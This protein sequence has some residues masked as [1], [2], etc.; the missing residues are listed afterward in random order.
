ML[1]F[2]ASRDEYVKR[3]FGLSRSAIADQYCKCSVCVQAKMKSTQIRSLVDK[4]RFEIGKMWY[5]DLSGPFVESLIRKNVYMAVFVDSAAR[6]IISYYMRSKEGIEV[7]KVLQLFVAEYLISPRFDKTKAF[8]FLQSDNGEFADKKIKLL[9]WKSG[10]VQRYSAPYHSVSNGPVERAILKIKEMGKAFLIEKSMP[11]EYWEFSARMAVYVLNRTP[12]KYRNKW[13]EDA[14]SKFFGVVAD[15]T[16]F[17]IPFSVAYVLKPPN[18][19]RKDWGP[20]ACEGVLVGISDSTYTVFVPEFN[21]LF[22]SSNVTID[23][24]ATRSDSSGLHGT[25]QH[26]PFK[27]AYELTDFMYLVGTEH[28]DDENGLKYRVVKVRLQRLRHGS[29]VVVDRMLVGGSEW[30]TIFALD[31]AVSTGPFPAHL[32]QSGL[33]VRPATGEHQPERIVTVVSD[34]PTGCTNAVRTDDS[35]APYQPPNSQ[36]EHERLSQRVN[37]RLKGP[38][39]QPMYLPKDTRKSTRLSSKPPINFHLSKLTLVES[40]QVD[41]EVLSY[42]IPKRYAQAIA[43]ED[44]E[45]WLAA[46]TSE[47]KGLQEAECWIIEPMPLGAIALPCKWVYDVKTDDMGRLIRYK[48]RLVV[49]GNRQR[50]GVDFSETFSPTVSWDSVRLFLALTVKFGLVPLQLDINMAYLYA[51]IDEG[52]VIYMRPPPGMDVPDGY[53][54]RLLKRLY[55]FK[56]SGRNW[57]HLIHQKLEEAGFMRIDEDACVYMRVRDGK[58]T[59]LLIYVDDILCSASSKDLLAELLAYLRSL[60]KLKVMGVPTNIHMAPSQL[61]G[62]QLVWGDDFK[63]VQINASKIVNELLVES[64]DNYGKDAVAH[65]TPMEPNLRL[66]ESDQLKEPVDEDDI[67]MQSKYR[68]IVG[69]LIFLVTTCRVELSFAL[70]VLSRSMK[71][72]GRAHYKAA[73]HVLAY[74]SNKADLG[75]AYYHDGNRFPY[76]YADADF[77]SDE[78]RRA[79]MGYMFILAG[80]PISWKCK[81]SDAIPLS[82]CEAEILSVHAAHKACQHAI[83][84]KKFLESIGAETREMQ[85]CTRRRSELL[86]PVL[87]YEDNKAAISWSQNPVSMTKMKHIDRDLKWIRKAVEEKTIVFEWI[88]S[89]KQ[90]AD[91]FTKA[92]TVLIFEHLLPMYMITKAVFMKNNRRHR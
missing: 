60:F 61:L 40:H 43:C 72:P 79:Y 87:I 80:G 53:F 55:G 34:Q 42:Y 41:G 17:K 83:F 74:L 8:I 88:K 47:L 73:Q 82:T 75:I 76:A 67:A 50:E 84:L 28:I 3:G 29:F 9:S 81:M 64:W 30:D 39:P 24:A 65:R 14:V 19:L 62:I 12:Y 15:Y 22:E 11:Q 32:L 52:L 5:V 85:I 68:H 37:K 51:L 21:R 54:L 48:A 71:N 26:F 70:C 6:L 69:V 10:I 90:L 45:H 92:V 86:E 77:G 31:A 27:R 35:T 46:M 33:P 78:T 59:L 44:A 38:S 56:Q 16:R 18:E 57:N 7:A 4:S 2:M 63:S 23:E 13:Q 66:A 89:E 49:C 36:S 58:I 91:V 20:R 25:T 1:K